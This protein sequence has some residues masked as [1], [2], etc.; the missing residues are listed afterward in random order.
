MFSS[1]NF[2]ILALVEVGIITAIVGGPLVGLGVG[3]G[4]LIWG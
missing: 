3:I 4:W 1:A 2:G